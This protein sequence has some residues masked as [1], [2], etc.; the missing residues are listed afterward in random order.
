MAQHNELG[1]AGEHAA[2]EFLIA[3]GMT[4]LETNWR[5]RHIEVDIIALTP[6]KLHIVEVKT[7]H[8]KSK[9]F[10]PLDAIDRKK[11]QN[12]I[13]A[14]NIYLRYYRLRLEVQFD[15]IVVYGQEGQFEI[16]YMPRA[17]TAPLK[18]YH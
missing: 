12:L 16:N 13:N 4:I 6:G 3:Q 17:F 11:I 5:Y 9:G 18:T 2:A 15:V 8:A 7:R 1:A 14:S 10:S